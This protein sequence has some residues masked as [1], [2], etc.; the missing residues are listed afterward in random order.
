MNK[1]N[2][3]VLVVAA[4][5]LVILMGVSCYAALQKLER[6]AQVTERMDARLGQAMEA[7]APVGHAAV[8]K[9]VQA[10]NEVD[11]KDLGKSATNGVKQIGAAAKER[12]LELMKSSKKDKTDQE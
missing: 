1:T 2:E 10:L 7:A 12:A 6:I 3:R 11:A 5:A 9:G 4:V 8:E